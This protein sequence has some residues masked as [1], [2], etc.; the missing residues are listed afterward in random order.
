M[1]LPYCTQPA[2]ASG[3]NKDWS[4]KDKDKDYTCK[5]KDK[6]Q[7]HKDK[8]KDLKL[9]LKEPLRT[10]TRINITGCSLL[11]RSLIV[12]DARCVRYNESS[13]YCHDVRLSVWDGRAL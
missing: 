1:T 7:T 6:D 12:S 5:D 10:R 13:R 4:H 3:V 9:A 8:D 11:P 2:V